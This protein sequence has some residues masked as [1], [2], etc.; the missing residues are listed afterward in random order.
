[1]RSAIAI[2]VAFFLIGTLPGCGGGDGDRLTGTPKD[3][4]PGFMPPAPPLTQSPKDLAKTK[5]G[6]NFK[7][8][9]RPKS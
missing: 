3:L 2:G 4:P 1:M 8:A 5:R 7:P 6:G 9:A